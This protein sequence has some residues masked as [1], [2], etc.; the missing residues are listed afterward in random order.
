MRGGSPLVAG[1]GVS[2]VTGSR[3]T[4]ERREATCGELCLRRRQ[5][6][7]LSPT[8]P[9]SSNEIATLPRMFRIESI[10][11]AASS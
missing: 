3:R 2:E 5:R 10:T 1:A 11:P 6:L 8:F 7:D 4:A 9:G